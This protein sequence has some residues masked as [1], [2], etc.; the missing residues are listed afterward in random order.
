MTIILDGKVCAAALTSNIAAQ[1]REHAPLKPGLAVILV[2]DDP[3][4][5]VYVHNKAKKCEEL[6]M[7][8]LEYTLPSSTSST[9]LLQVIHDLN[10]NPSIHGILLQLPLPKHLDAQEMLAHINPAKDVDGFHPVN[11]GRLHL[12][13]PG[14]VPCTPLGCMR[15]LDYYIKEPV[16]GLHAVVVGRSNIVGKPLAALLLNHDCTVTTVHSKTKHIQ[17]ICREADIL[18]A[19]I[20]KP[21]YI[22]ADY[23]KE[24]AIVLD[25]GINRITVSGK[26]K[27]VGDTDYEGILPKAR[28]ITPV[29]GGIG[30]MTI[31]C[32]ME[33]TFRGM[34]KAQ[35]T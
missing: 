25:V 34:M 2:G 31:A 15:L 23:V 8:S 12:G 35:E 32:L 18:V 16:T 28:A 30:P 13:L 11:V 19:A 22:T 27:L 9:E 6:G 1:I 20:G 7:Y 5:Q 33:N 3:A 17:E 26:N 21:K 29:P 10:Q 24:G 4:S 14:F